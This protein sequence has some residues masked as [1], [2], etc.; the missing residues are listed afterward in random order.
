MSKYGLKIKKFDA[1]TIHEY[2][3][4]LRSYMS[5][6]DAMLCNSLFLYYIRDNGLTEHNGSTRDII[7]LDFNFGSRSYEEDAKRAKDNPEL[8]AKIEANKDKYHKITK[9]ELREQFYKNGI[10]ITYAN[11][12]AMSYRMLYRNPSKAKVGQVMFINE[13]LYERAYDWLTM[14]LGKQKPNKIVELSAY[15]PLT[16]STIESTF[17]LSFDDLLIVSEGQSKTKVNAK[18]VYANHGNAAVKDEMVEVTN[19]VWDGMALIEPSI[20]P[21]NINGMALLRNHFFKACAFKARIQLFIKDWCESKGV[22]YDSLK[23]QDCFGNW[24]LAKNIKMITTDS[25][26]KWMKFRQY[27]G[28]NPY[29]YW[30]ERCE[31]FPNEE[32]RSFSEFGI[33]KTD[34]PSKLEDVQQMSYQMVN[35][36]P[37]TEDDI[38]LLAK[39]S[40][41]YVEALKKNERVF[42]KFLRKNA[43]IVNH[44]DMMADLYEWNHDFADSAWYRREKAV[45]IKSYVDK[46]KTGKITVPGDNLTVCGNPY[47]LLLHAVGDDWTKDPTFE[48]EENCIQCYAPMFRDREYLC[49]IRNPHN[50]PNNL[51]YLHNHKNPEMQRYFE[52]SKN[53]VAVNC[54]KTDIQD[55]MN[56][57]DFDLT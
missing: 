21:K 17:R 8:L 4:G 1:A 19:N 31:G 40:M 27:M 15:A 5:Y 51:A 54:I 25:S 36:L 35:T 56:G 57:A 11:G 13:K 53:I 49:A 18:V 39:N 52:F 34:H 55:R 41:D 48:N 10:T 44:Y 30:K 32:K 14:G 28:D 47:G 6:S 22:D 12:E 37:C 2:N 38:N 16:T 9:E 24:H 50:S 3:L 33:V 42:T 43:N 26:V 46:L 29:E 45:I 23:L 20:L 7:C